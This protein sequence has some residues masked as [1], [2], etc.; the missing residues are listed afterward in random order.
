[1]PLDTVTVHNMYN[2]INC[3]IIGVLI[4]YGMTMHTSKLHYYNTY[5]IHGMTMHTSNYTSI[6]AIIIFLL[7]YIVSIN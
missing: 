7:H 4:Y 2:Q 5:Y 1:M 3:I 6:P